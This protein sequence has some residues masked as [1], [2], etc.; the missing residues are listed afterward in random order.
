MKVYDINTYYYNVK[1]RCLL[2]PMY[3][4]TYRYG[5]KTYPVAING[6]NGKTLFTVPRYFPQLIAAAVIGGILLLVLYFA[7]LY[8]FPDSPPAQFYRFIYGN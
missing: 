5:K 4:A 1:F 3:F 7:C 8:F 6:Q 2:A